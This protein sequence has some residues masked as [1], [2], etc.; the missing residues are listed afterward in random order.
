MLTLI[1]VPLPALLG[2]IESVFE[3]ATSFENITGAESF[4]IGI[5]EGRMSYGSSG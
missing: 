1:L 5:V 3:P 2:P 4:V